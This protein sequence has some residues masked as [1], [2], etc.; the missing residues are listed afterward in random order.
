MIKELTKK[1]EELVPVYLKKWLD[2]GYRTETI[3]Q[4]KCKKAID[5]LYA[6]ILSMEKPKY[7]VFLDSPMACQLAM[8]LIKGSSIDVNQLRSQLDSQLDSQLYN[9]LGS[10]LDSQL[11]NQLYNQLRSQLESQLGSQLYNQLRS[12][13]G[14]QLYN[15]LRSQLGSQ[16]YNQ[17][18]NQLDSQLYSQKLTYFYSSGGNWW[19][20]YYWLWSYDFILNELFPEKTKQPEFLKFNKYMEGIKQYH[21]IY[22]CKEIVFTSDFPKEINLNSENRLHSD[23][24]AALEYRDGYS[25]HAL[26]GIVMPKELVLLRPEEITKELILKLENADHRRELV[27]KLNSQQLLDVLNPKVIDSKFGYELLAIDLGD[28]RIR[29]FLKMQNPSIDA[30]HIEGCPPLTDT[31]EKAIIFRNSLDQFS[32]PRTLD[33]FIQGP[34]SNDEYYA[35]GDCLFFPGDIPSEAIKCNHN[36]AGDGLIRHTIINGEIYELDGIRYILAF[37]DCEI[38]HPEHKSTFLSEGVSYRVGK[39]LEYSHWDEEAREIVD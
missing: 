14:S 6:D 28:D 35:Q 37:K 20:R 8:N 33:G 18:Y 5:F 29:P 22:L 21:Q 27:R 13:L 15:Q 11:D 23:I 26:N 4:E 12:Q 16:L 9:Q 36:I 1:Q 24:G 7:Y 3:D 19:P 38:T 30:I 34:S 17:L 32:L 25:I 39:V 31:V 10:Q 2:V